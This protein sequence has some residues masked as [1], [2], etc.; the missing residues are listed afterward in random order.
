MEQIRFSYSMK[1]IP[2]PTR[3][4]YLKKLIEKTESVIKRMRWKAFFYERKEDC[5]NTS[6]DKNSLGFKSRKCPPRI[7]DLECF[8]TDLLNMI[9]NIEFKKTYSTFKTN[10]EAIQSKSRPPLKHSYQLIKPPTTTSLTKIRT[11]NS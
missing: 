4:S 10:S 5:N 8:E 2:L 7:E 9:K 1:N 3:N 11:R 6:D